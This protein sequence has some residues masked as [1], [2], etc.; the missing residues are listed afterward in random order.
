M[1]GEVSLEP[2]SCVLV[3]V[4]FPLRLVFV[5]CFELYLV[6]SIVKLSQQL[7]CTVPSEASNSSS[8]ILCFIKTTV[9]SIS[10]VLSLSLF[11]SYQPPSRKTFGIN[12]ISDSF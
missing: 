5:S 9:A 10:K 8:T 4:C 12:Y 6:Q 1:D 11:F 3:C 7:Y 2:H